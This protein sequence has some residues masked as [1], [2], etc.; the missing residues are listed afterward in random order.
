MVEARRGLT[1]E[2]RFNALLRDKERLRRERLQ[3]ELAGPRW[4]RM[5][6]IIPVL[7]RMEGTFEARLLRAEAREVI[8]ALR[9]DGVFALD[10]AMRLAHGFGFLAGGDVQ[11]Y[12]T[13]PEPLSRLAEAGLVEAQPYTDPV[14]VRPWAGPPRLLA[15]V[16]AEMPPSRLVGSGY[17]VVTAER[18]GREMI[19]AVGARADLFAAFEKAEERASRA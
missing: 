5:V 16:V 17:R 3:R 2:E 6:R 11:V 1:A 13:S 19:G 10:T 14:L 7:F 15:C 9:Q 4:H 18:L 8:E 12:L